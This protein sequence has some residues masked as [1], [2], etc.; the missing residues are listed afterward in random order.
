MSK[1]KKSVVLALSLLVAM[2]VCGQA[3]ANNEEELCLGQCAQDR[4]QKVY[5]CEDIREPCLDEAQDYLVDIVEPL[6]FACANTAADPQ[7]GPEAVAATCLAAILVASNHREMVDSCWSDFWVCSDQ[8]HDDEIT[9][10]QSNC[11]GLGG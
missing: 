2:V 9:C 4:E 1:T 10:I 7:I 6:Q 8:A 3:E 5:E 11:V